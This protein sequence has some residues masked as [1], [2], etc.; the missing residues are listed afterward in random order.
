MCNSLLIYCFDFIQPAVPPP[1]HVQVYDLQAKLA[2]GEVKSS[3]T[4]ACAAGACQLVARAA[5]LEWATKILK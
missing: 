4:T 2:V 1:T 3:S 5:L